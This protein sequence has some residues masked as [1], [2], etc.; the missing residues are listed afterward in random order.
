MNK[1]ELIADLNS[2]V[3]KVI[4]TSAANNVN[5]GDVE[6]S[7]N[8]VINT[9]SGFQE[10]NYSIRVIDEG[11]ETEVANYIRK[12]PPALVGR[13]AMLKQRLVYLKTQGALV[14]LDISQLGVPFAKFKIDGAIKYAVDLD[15]ELVIED[16]E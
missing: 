13:E 1:A 15:G 8:T 12:S 4:S 11:L 5:G 3:V 7:Y 6:Y 16:G 14:F 2:R 10:E 9:P